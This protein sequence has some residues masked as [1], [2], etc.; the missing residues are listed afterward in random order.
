MSRTSPATLHLASDPNDVASA[1]S[2]WQAA[3]QPAASLF[4]LGLIG[5][6]V[7]AL[8][9]GDFALV[10]QPVAPWVPGRTALAY[11]SGILMLGSGAGLLMRATASWAAR[12]LF[13]YLIVWALLKVPAL[14]V[15]PKIEGVWLGFGELAMLLAGGWVLFARLAEVRADS[16][17]AFAAGDRGIRI[18]RYLF[19]VWVIPVG[20]SH[21][22]YT[23]ATID[24]IPAWIP[25]RM[26][27]AYLTGAGHVASGLGVLFSVAPRLAVF[28]EAGMLS[29]IT[30]LV[31]AP[32]VLTHPTVRMPW[33]A[34]WI[35][36]VITA[37][38]WVLAQGMENRKPRGPWSK[39]RPLH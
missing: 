36:W 14:F 38:V 29:A 1:Q 18:A 23:K 17:L 13:P 20:L 24:L 10:W 19:A 5:L 25:G 32:A 15:A 31:W 11:G 2:V 9:Y 26:F 21:F 30:L 37:A 27:W 35:S 28:A 33:T 8:V 39:S 34:F 7:L 4:A 22:F 12:V 3:L 16:W 6:G